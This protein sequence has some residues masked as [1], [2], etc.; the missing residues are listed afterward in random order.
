MESKIRELIIKE[1]LPNLEKYLRENPSFDQK[2]SLGVSP[3]IFAIMEKKP[4]VFE[5]LIGF[6]ISYLEDCLKTAAW[7]GQIELIDKIIQKGAKGLDEALCVAAQAGK[8]EVIKHL[9]DKH[10]ANPQK[11][12]F[13]GSPLLSHAVLSDNLDLIVYLIE[14]KGV[15]LTA[16]DDLG[17]KPTDLALA[18]GYKE[19]SDYLY[20]KETDS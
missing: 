6:K 11:A 14:D 19:I 13:Q 20:A 4:K 12:F 18:C 3:S 5:M 16:L 1:D 7:T 10:H 2:N 15:D 9:I 17:M 8:I